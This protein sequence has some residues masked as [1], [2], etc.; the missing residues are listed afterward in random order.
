MIRSDAKIE[1]ADVV[2]QNDHPL[3]DFLLLLQLN[4]K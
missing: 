3:F 2:I 4:S 1:K